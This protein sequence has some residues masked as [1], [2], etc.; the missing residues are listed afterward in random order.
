MTDTRTREEKAY[1]RF[2]EV[3]GLQAFRRNSYNLSRR[4]VLK[5]SAILAMG[6][7]GALLLGCGDEEEV[8]Q[9]TQAASPTQTAA[10]TTAT[11]A[12]GTGGTGAAAAGA[13]S[14]IASKYPLVGQHNWTKLDWTVPPVT[15]GE[16]VRSGAPGYGWDILTV[17]TS[18]PHPPF[19]NGLYRTRL[20]AGSNLWGQEFG[21][22]LAQT[23]EH[24]ADFTEW[25]FT[26]PRNVKFHDLPPVNG[27]QMTAEDVAYSINTYRTDSLW[28]TPLDAVESVE[29]IDDFTVKFKMS[30]PY[31]TLPNILGMPYY[32][33]FAQEHRE[34]PDERWNLQPIGTG[35]FMVTEDRPDELLRAE[36]HPGYW[37][38]GPDGVQ[39]PYLDKMTY[40]EHTDRNARTAAFRSGQIDEVHL[41][42]ESFKAVL[43]STPEANFTVQPH[44]ATYQWGLIWQWENPLFQDVRVR[45]ALSMAIDRKGIVDNLLGGAGTPGYPVPFDQQGLAAPL[46]WDDMPEAMRYNP[47][48]AKELLASAGYPDGLKIQMVT[49][50]SEIEYVVLAQQYWNDIGVDMSYDEKDFATFQNLLYKK[51]FNELAY[52][53]GIAGFDADVVVRPLYYPGASS[54]WGNVND[55]VLTGLLD[56]LHVSIDADERQQLA[57]Q[58]NERVIGQAL[59]LWVAGYH[60]FEASHP[61]VHTIAHSTYTTILNWGGAAWRMV[62]LD[63]SAPGGRGG[64]RI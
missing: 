16:Y 54:N 11:P 14:D 28:S 10:Q 2:Q 62:K 59:Q 39:L 24:N 45:Q 44:W 35:P 58:V 6:G 12:A 30:I 57:K 38:K 50:N 42:L 36:R 40:I 8:A 20:E 15:G 18:T 13:E 27:R 21:P 46:G 9:A 31:F 53:G 61:W 4:R 17:G 29:A 3:E 5:G 23:T 37:E 47:Q 41:D 48:K 33:I 60:T 52:Y 63:E 49:H 56:K 34:G 22:D 55:D 7:V 32:L 1:E 26:L 25:V 19:Y 43:D 51:D 64:H